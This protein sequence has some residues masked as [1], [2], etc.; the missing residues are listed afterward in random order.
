MFHVSNQTM[1]FQISQG[2]K[3]PRIVELCEFAPNVLVIGEDAYDFFAQSG[4]EYYV[5]IMYNK[6]KKTRQSN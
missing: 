5:A 6:Y 1:A 3:H 2:L 4:L